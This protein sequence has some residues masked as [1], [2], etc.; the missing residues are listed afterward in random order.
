MRYVYIPIEIS[1][2][3][4]TSALF[5]AALFADKESRVV[6]INNW[7]FGQLLN[8][9]ALPPGIVI[10]KDLS[11]RGYF[12]RLKNAKQQHF[13]IASKI[14]EDLD[15]GETWHSSLYSD[16][17]AVDA[18]DFYLAGF[19]EDEVK[20]KASF[21]HSFTERDSRKIIRFPEP[22]FYLLR[23]EF[24]I[25]YQSK[26]AAFRNLYGDFTLL[27]LSDRPSIDE[28]RAAQVRK[29]DKK[30]YEGSLLTEDE[31][32][33]FSSKKLEISDA[34]AS[35]NSKIISEIEKYDFDSLNRLVIRPHPSLRH[36]G[37]DKLA[38]LYSKNGTEICLVGSF[39]EI[40]HASSRQITGPCTTYLASMFAENNKSQLINFDDS[41]C[42]SF[43]FSSS[44]SSIQ[45]IDIALDKRG[46]KILTEAAPIVSNCDK[47]FLSLCHT[48]P[49]SH[50]FTAFS[51][52]DVHKFEDL[53]HNM[54]IS[55]NNVGLLQ[56][57]TQKIEVL[58]ISH[59]ICMF[60]VR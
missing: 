28:S 41:S 33:L 29:N 51:R 30:F 37:L 13:L 7:Y 53:V 58:H 21:A 6:L 47:H 44:L 49:V 59:D 1:Q 56:K 10:D 26:V 32:K 25:C 38:K 31:I 57:S 4:L 22:R 40:Y 50:K 12:Q 18:L 5:Y 14:L 2:R 36:T 9:K 20:I 45:S 43:R 19:Y 24:E 11:H 8:V 16:K 3:E 27:T 48:M 35:N 42:H 23:K 39:E 34:L 60:G 17:R 54:F 52:S 55:Q 15:I 46:I